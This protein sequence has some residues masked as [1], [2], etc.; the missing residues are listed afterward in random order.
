[1]S[2]NPQVNAKPSSGAG[3]AWR[4]AAFYAALFVALGV[5]LPFLPVWLAAQGLDAGTI[6][7]ALA[8][9][10]VVRVFSIPFATRNAD[11]RDALRGALLIAAAA[12]A[13][14]YGALGL[15]RGA[16]AIM[17]AFAFASAFY[18]P[19]MPLT[20]AYALRGLSPSPASG[21]G[22]RRAGLRA[23]G[24][25]R[26][27]GSAAFVAGT[28]GAGFML[29]VIAA[30]DLIWLIVAALVATAALAF[31][32][33]PLA[34]HVAAAMGQSSSARALLRDRGFLAIVAA[35]SLIQASHAV[36]YGF[37]A[38][39]WRSAGFDGMAIAALWATGVVAEIVLFAV[40]GR[41]ALR[42]SA[43]LL[44][45][46]A[47]AV[48]RWGAMAFDPPVLLLVPLQCLHALSFGA[49][50]LGTLG[51]MTRTVPPELGATAQGYLAVA[52]GLVMA[53]VMGLSGLLYA[54]WG[55]LTYGAMALV[56]AAGGLLAWAART[57]SSEGSLLT[58]RSD[59]SPRARDP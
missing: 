59:T 11:R 16:L 13:L 4:L 56:A 46:A 30:R 47:G 19:I 14:G 42:P 23:F 35:A 8:I 43:L 38:L 32:L 18:T 34:P 44:I 2:S 40:S 45:G 41:L 54:R 25:V 21:A 39:D 49:T 33:E 57:A 55:G 20:D 6:G 12:A 58:G 53:A 50:F 52:L 24:P 22:L 48:I 17:A 36:Y 3:F 29:D 15:A 27:W 31:A 37:S 28:F 26:L 10:Q 9:P 51:L 5:Q 1:M 7:I